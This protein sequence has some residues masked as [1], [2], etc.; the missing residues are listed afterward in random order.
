MRTRTVYSTNFIPQQL[1][2]ILNK[3]IQNTEKQIIHDYQS[4][5]SIIDL[6]LKY[7]MDRNKIYKILHKHKISLQREKKTA[8]SLFEIL[9]K[10][11]K[12]SYNELLKKSRIKT[13]ST[14]SH[15]LSELVRHKKIRRIRE[16][17]PKCGNHVYNYSVN[18]KGR[19]S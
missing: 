5:I 17:C 11:K 8:D 12:M 3:K 16:Y 4:G 19:Q 10:K 14:F 7:K 18:T 6:E 13:V 2:Q 9:C 1:I 15:S